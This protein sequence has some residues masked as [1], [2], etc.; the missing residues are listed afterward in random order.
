MTKSKSAVAIAAM[1][2]SITASR[3]QETY[4]PPTFNGTPVDYC[5][6]HGDM[7]SCGRESANAYCVAQGQPGVTSFKGYVVVPSAITMSGQTCSGQCWAFES[8]QC[9]EP[10]PSAASSAGAAIGQHPSV[11]QPVSSAPPVGSYEFLVGDKPAQ[12]GAVAADIPEAAKVNT[13]PSAAATVMSDEQRDAAEK[14]AQEREA[15]ERKME[16]A[17][18]RVLRGYASGQST[19]LIQGLYD[20]LFNRDDPFRVFFHMTASS[21]EAL[22]MLESGRWHGRDPE[23]ARSAGFPTNYLGACSPQA[24]LSRPSE[25]QMIIQLGGVSNT[26]APPPPVNFG[27]LGDYETGCMGVVYASERPGTIPLYRYIDQRNGAHFFTLS[28]QEGDNAVRILGFK[29]EGVCCFVPPAPGPGIKPVYRVQCSETGHFYTP[30][31]FVKDWMVLKEQC[32]DEGIAF[33]VW[34]S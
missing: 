13:P 21:Q 23:G 17:D 6:R 11:G 24:K 16:L 14:A 2:L 3:A 1:M 9:G 18:R 30:Q 5:L 19:S 29:S 32:V 26:I 31:P 8:I 22:D 33:H 7:S 25:R 4:G 15:A 12:G 27:V 28:A 10:G 20:Y 34:E